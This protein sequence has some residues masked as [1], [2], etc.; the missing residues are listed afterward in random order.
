MSVSPPGWKAIAAVARNR[1]IGRAGALPWHLPEDLQWFKQCTLGQ[2]VVMGRKTW[3]SLPRALPRRIN[4]VVSR[5]LTEA[6][7]AI[8]VPDLDAIDAVAAP[9]R[10]IW[11][12]GGAALYA[13]ALR[14]TRLRQLYLTR[15]PDDYEGDVRFPELGL[16]WQLAETIRSTPTHTIE[17][18]ERTIP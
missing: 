6:P 15:L 17:R 11:L 1:V 18:Y 2:T 13:E 5:T 7:G 16:E 12:I 3:Q 14:G 8:I 9:G 10:E 4:L